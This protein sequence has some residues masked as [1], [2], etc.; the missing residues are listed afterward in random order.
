[1]GWL[2]DRK[3]RQIGTRF[4]WIILMLEETPCEVRNSQKRHRK[5]QD[6]HSKHTQKTIGSNDT[7]Y[8]PPF[9]Q[10]VT[11]DSTNDTS[12]QPLSAILLLGA[13]PKGWSHVF[14]FPR[15]THSFR[16]VVFGFLTWCLG[17]QAV[18]TC[19]VHGN[20]LV[21]WML[22][23]A[24]WLLAGVFLFC[25]STSVLVQFSWQETPAALTLVLDVRWWPTASTQSVD[26][27]GAG[28]AL[29]AQA[30]GKATEH[31]VVEGHETCRRKQ[32]HV[33]HDRVGEWHWWL[34]S[35]SKMKVRHVAR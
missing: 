30:E 28:D 22:Q 16:K 5:K 17:T 34:A 23:R 27:H 19:G 24:S 10:L 21:V 7:A 20:S 2:D 25:R 12:N 31:G 29:G 35:V 33:F 32:F 4:Q 18:L 11:G 14:H 26:C 3:R 1:M 13:R 9:G 8:L 15:R 6:T